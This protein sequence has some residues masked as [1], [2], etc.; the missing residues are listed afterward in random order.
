[1]TEPTGETGGRWGRGCFLRELCQ[2]AQS[3]FHLPPT[4]RNCIRGNLCWQLK[5]VTSKIDCWS[6]KALLSSPV[7]AQSGSVLIICKQFISLWV[8]YTSQ[9]HRLSCLTCNRSQ[10]GP[11]DTASQTA[12][13][14]GHPPGH[15]V[16]KPVMGHTSGTETAILGE[17]MLY[18][19]TCV[20]L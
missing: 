18:C 3:A 1:M 19:E 20:G 13:Y 16:C 12:Q 10:E 2:D 9:K 8:C 14:G 11:V 6:T 4:A 15:C 17:A 5:S 7:S